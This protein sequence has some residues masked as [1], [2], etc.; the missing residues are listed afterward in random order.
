MESGC[1]LIRIGGTLQ[2]ADL[3][4]F[5]QKCTDEEAGP[6]WDGGF[7]NDVRTIKQ[8]YELRDSEGFNGCLEL[9]H[10]QAIGS[11]F[12]KLEEWLRAHLLPY[13]RWT[14]AGI[15][16]DAYFDVWR[17]DE[18]FELRSDKSYAVFFPADDTARLLKA[19][20]RGQRKRD[21]RIW[22][23]QLATFKNLPP[24]EVRCSTENPE[25]CLLCMSRR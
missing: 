8:L 18:Y 1:A 15:E 11:E 25:T 19:L 5:I 21:A 22:R 4:E 14:D 10:N 24:F 12:E 7:P 2:C 6:E 16:W 3:E 23:E 13:N 20:A 17:P 9:K